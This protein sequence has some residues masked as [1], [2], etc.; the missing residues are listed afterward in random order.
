LKDAN[1][2]RRGSHCH[3]TH[4]AGPYPGGTSWAWRSCEN[5]RCLNLVTRIA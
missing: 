3:C 4:N 1:L 5:A 2:N